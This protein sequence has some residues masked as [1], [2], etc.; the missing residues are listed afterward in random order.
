MVLIDMIWCILVTSITFLL[1][2]GKD[3][4]TS[5]GFFRRRVVHNRAYSRQQNRGGCHG[6]MEMAVAKQPECWKQR[7]YLIS[8]WTNSCTTNPDGP[9]KKSNVMWPFTSEIRIRTGQLWR[10]FALLL[11]LFATKLDA[12]SSSSVLSSSFVSSVLPSVSSSTLSTRI[13]SITS[14]R[15]GGIS[16][17]PS[18]KYGK[19]H[20]PCYA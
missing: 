9:D 1:A 10:C 16:T 13:Q 4:M 12:A 6:I 17:A 8:K 2:I 11:A 14:S 18:S 19:I 20:Y 7:S 15:N 5:S 3:H